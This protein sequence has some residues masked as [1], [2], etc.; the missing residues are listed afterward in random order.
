MRVS[1]FAGTATRRTHVR[2]GIEQ[3][4]L[5]PEIS[6]VIPTRN[7]ADNVAALL[8]RIRSALKG[9]SIEVLFVDDSD[10]DTPAAIER[11]T[12]PGEQVMV[13]HR[14]PHDRS[15]GLGGAVVAGM[16]RAR[17]AWVCVM[18]GDLQHPPEVVADLWDRTRRGDVDLVIASRFC[19]GGGVGEFGRARGIL[20]KLS[21]LSASAL[22]RRSIATVSDPM[23]GFFMVRRSSV[24]LD[25]LR[26]TG[27]KILLEILV[28]SSGLSVAEA[29]FEFGTRHSGDSK[30]NT[31]EGLRYLRQ[32][33]RLRLASM[34]ARFGR[35]GVVGLTGLV[36][37]TALLALL[38]DAGG[39]GYIAAALLA[40]QGSTLWNF[41]LTDRFVF[42]GRAM[43][44]S[45]VSRFTL[46][47]GVNNAALLL[48]IPLL[49][50]LTSE[51]GVHYLA[52]NVVS[53]VSLTIL[54]F[55]LS[56]SWIWASRK[57]AK[58]HT[59][60]L[61]GIITVASDTTLP[62]LERF[63]V[64]VDI[65]EPTVRVRIGKVRPRAASAEP[66]IDGNFVSYVEKLG[67]VGFGAEI[68]MGEH[69]VDVLASP[70]LR[71]SP[72]VLYTNVVEPILRWSFVERGYALIHAACLAT[73]GQ[74]VLITARTDTGK[75]T[76]AL[77]TLDSQ[78]FAFVSDDLT[79][80]SPD[81]M[82]LSYPKPLTISRHTLSSVK[83]PL[84]SRKERFA[85]VFQ[86]R[87]HSKSGR[88]FGMLI[89]KLGLPAA[90][91][92]AIVQLLVP[93]PKYQVDRLVPGVEIASE[94]EPAARAL[95]Q[96]EG[97]AFERLDPEE[98]LQILMSNCDDAYGFPPYPLIEHFFHSRAGAD[99]KSTEQAIVRH[100]LK[101]IPATLLK[102]PTRDWYLM[103]P[104]VVQEGVSARTVERET[105]TRVRHLEPVRERRMVIGE[106]EVQPATGG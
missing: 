100:A 62:E 104:Q 25:D 99:L 52:A 48:R 75:T 23:S 3:E 50:A 61:H 43:Q 77:K 47:L 88:L 94:A 30:A 27:F 82:I 68:E 26:P 59:Y 91:M 66:F 33:W 60:D 96:R 81:G 92:N 84:L 71:R 95:I 105:V 5:A 46:F 20:S 21:T 63:R 18:D 1:E 67:R 69:Q 31:T 90:T 35:F 54:R 80:I 11:A 103:L 12:L 56:D 49:W 55:G 24:E 14:A 83:T 29:P 17:S 34:A 38:V 98:A 93:P 32:L 86:S 79:L 85:L 36:V 41:L 16:R 40:T 44:R 76:T 28:R 58:L 13:I 53:L 6:L 78:P 19:D 74:A 65:P 37:N 10:D 102:S 8:E 15:G 101:G 2:H 57:A 89:A 70:L 39:V 73:D 45:S 87:L 42:R 7:E 106:A 97:D 64:D 4:S 9:R 22:F 51:L 72:H